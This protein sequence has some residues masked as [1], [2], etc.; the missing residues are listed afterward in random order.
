MIRSD[1]NLAL[2]ILRQIEEEGVRR[3][4]REVMVKCP[5]GIANF[6]MNQKREHIGQIEARYG[7]AVRVEGD[8]ALV[9]PDFSI[10]KLKTATRVISEL[11]Q[12]VVSV[13]SKI[14]DQIDAETDED[15]V[16]AEADVEIEAVDTTTDEEQKPKKRRRRRRRRKSNGLDGDDVAHS[17]N[18]EP[19]GTS[20]A[21]E[22]NSADETAQSVSDKGET[23]AA[24][25]APDV[26]EPT[27]MAENV[28]DVINTTGNAPVEAAATTA[29]GHTADVADTSG[30]DEAPKKPTRRRSVTPRKRASKK[31]VGDATVDEGDGVASADTPTSEAV[32][33]E[34]VQVDA[35]G[36]EPVK[37]PRRRR[38]K[39]DT[40]VETATESNTAEPA[41]P[42]AN[43][44]TAPEITPVSK[45]DAG[46]QTA[47]SEAE[48]AAAAPAAELATE[49]ALDV[50]QTPPEPEVAAKPKKRG[51][52]SLGK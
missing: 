9:S 18:A 40:V 6:L 34:I 51:W 17:E 36:T 11:P 41:V 32:T 4:S 16:S 48:A 25:D 3:R 5:V 14:L 12:N 33:A 1:D 35:E 7:L 47:V 42:V 37:K 26:A 23:S 8:P 38:K 10:E 28:T 43:N 13:D 46:S 15:E 2:A 49:P 31:P 21:S 29:A 19:D 20:N 24:S 27:K 45:G 52:W 39:A 22:E 50:A 44:A 30:E